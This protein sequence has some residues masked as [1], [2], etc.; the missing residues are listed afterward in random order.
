MLQLLCDSIRC[1]RLDVRLDRGAFVLVLLLTSLRGIWR[2]TFPR[3]EHA[4]RTALSTRWV[5]SLFVLA[6]CVG[7][8]ELVY[9]TRRLR[10]SR[11]SCLLS[12]DGLR[13]MVSHGRISHGY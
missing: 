5:G 6:G 7:L 3:R 10:N 1:L 9:R 4:R 2:W 13:T 12:S 8:T 11:S